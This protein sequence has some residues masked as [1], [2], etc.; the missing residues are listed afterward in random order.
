MKVLDLDMEV[1]VPGSK[2]QWI[3]QIGSGNAA[4]KL[5]NIFEK[6]NALG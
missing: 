2:V 4:G 5:S 3:C 6:M 1:L